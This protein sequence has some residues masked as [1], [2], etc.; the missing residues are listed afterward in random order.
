MMSN[1]LNCKAVTVQASSRP[2]WF[3]E[4]EDPRLLD[5]RHMEVVRLAALRTGR[6]Y[7]P[8]KYCWYSFPLE[9]ESTRGP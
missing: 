7:P 4:F 3:Q 9:G 5:G 6:L 8:R 2:L 1:Q